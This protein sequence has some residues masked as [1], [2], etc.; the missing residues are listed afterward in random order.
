M[1]YVGHPGILG[2]SPVN[3]Q[4]SSRSALV[5]VLNPLI[6]AGFTKNSGSLEES[7]LF[8]AL[9]STLLG[10]RRRFALLPQMKQ[11]L[12]P[13]GWLICVLGVSTTT[14]CDKKHGSE[15]THL[16]AATG[17][18]CDR[19]ILDIKDVA[20]I[21]SAPITQVRSL[22]GDA[23]SCEFATGS[24]P[25]IVISVRPKVGRSTIEMWKTGHMPLPS[26]PLSG[27]GDEA[28]WQETLHELVSEKDALLCDIQVRGAGADLE[29]NAKSLPA[30]IGALCN[31]IFDAY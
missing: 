27:I 19:R 21:L 25:A 20:G 13:I 12:S 10:G 24:F 26:S 14:G 1:F 29:M 4:Q 15:K 7:T 5:R 16:G 8:S 28:V 6:V 31:K 2:R 18:V 30:A 17:S 11:F 23:E 9:L 22:P 3:V